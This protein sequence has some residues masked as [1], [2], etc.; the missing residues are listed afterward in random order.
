MA[1]LHT[2]CACVQ[3]TESRYSTLRA[4][5]CK[6]LSRITPHSARACKPLSRVTPHSAR[7]CK[8]LSRVTPHSACACKPLSRVTPHS[9]RGRANHWVTLLH[10]PRACGQTSESRYSTFLV[11]ACKSPSCVACYTRYT[12]FSVFQN[13]GFILSFLVF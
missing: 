3:T 5:L 9:A 7:A 11:R 8:P 4:R 10:T 12:F 13:L 2:P 6:P 1:L